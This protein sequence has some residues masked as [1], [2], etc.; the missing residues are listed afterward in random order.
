MDLAN[1]FGR[2]AFNFT[3][4]SS[5]NAILPNNDV[6]QTKFDAGT[7]KVNQ[8]TTNLDFSRLYEKVAGITSLNLAFGTEFRRNHYQIEAGE[9]SPYSGVV[10]SVPTA[11][12]TLGGP[13]AGSIVAGLGAQVFP[14][15]QPSNAINK[16][17]TNLSFYGDVEGEILSR[18]L[19]GIAG[20]Y[21]NYSD[22]G[23]NFSGKISGRL[24]IID[25]IA[26]RGSVS[27][28]FRAPSLHQRY[29]SNISTQF[30]SGLP[31]NTLTVN[32]DDPIARKVNG[33]DAFQPETSVS[34]TIGAT[35]RLAKTTTIT[36]DVY[37]IEIKDRVVYSGAFSRSLLGFATTDY[38]GVNNVNFFA[39][40]AN[41]RTQG[42]DV[43]VNSKNKVGKGSLN[44]TLAMNFNKNEVTA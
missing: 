14:G 5:G 25:A 22:F 27:T 15:F 40:A 43:V 21:E 9:T 13:A 33:V 37:Q 7:L 8:N 1:T 39:N 11:P 30:V 28:G 20:R 29:F 34:F 36:V 6:Q 42:V 31:S 26:L 38:I 4:N 35:A 32:Y 23:S 3:V 12:I 19:V 24:K 17:R 18:L 16:S 2:N 41:T 44:A 10:K